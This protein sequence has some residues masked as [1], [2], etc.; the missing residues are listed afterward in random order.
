MY[1]LAVAVDTFDG[2]FPE[3]HKVA[4]LTSAS[5]IRVRARGFYSLGPQ[6]E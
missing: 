1:S 6:R 4:K 3:Q 2:I 5:A